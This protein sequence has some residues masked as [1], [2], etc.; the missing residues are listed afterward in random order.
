MDTATPE[1]A[2]E[3]T[4]HISVKVVG[5]DGNVIFFKIKKSTPLRKLISAYCSKIGI[6]EDQMRFLFDGE[7]IKGDSTAAELEIEDG[8][9]IDA[10]LQQTGGGPT[11][12][13]FR[14]DQKTCYFCRD[15]LVERVVVFE[16]KLKECARAVRRPP[17][18][19]GCLDCVREFEVVYDSGTVRLT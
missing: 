19:A 2:K 17:Y 10:V 1:T 7:R 16:F 8:N 18:Y 15:K 6:K 14:S 13:K 9:I 3:P 5:Q 12:R 4:D 11:N